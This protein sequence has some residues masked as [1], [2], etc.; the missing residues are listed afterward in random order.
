MSR[1]AF[2]G[3]SV[4]CAVLILGAFAALPA[5]SQTAAP[6]GP[7][8]PAPELGKLAFFSGD[9]SCTGKAEASPMGPAH[10]TQ[11]KVRI[12]KE[13]GGFW[14]VGRYEETKTAE[15]P[16]P[17]VFQFFQGYN[18]ADKTFVMDCFD[19]FGNHCHQA[20]AGWQ[21]NKLAYNGEATGSGPALSVRD[22]FTRTGDAGLEHMG[23]LQIE[24]QWVVTDREA[25]KRRGK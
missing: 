3:W 12:S 20:S 8:A 9:W 17:V 4:V 15:N 13:I 25:C 22:T 10:A 11:G 2:G 21:G 19:S 6:E 24:G 16:H 1:R 14:Y 7:P 5:F 23:E 18:A